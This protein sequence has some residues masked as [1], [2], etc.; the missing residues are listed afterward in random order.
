[1]LASYIEILRH[2]VPLV[3]NITNFV[4]MNL[5][6][7][8]QIAVGASPAMVHSMEE[9][10]EFIEIADA[11]TINIGTVDTDWGKSM[12]AAA[13]IASKINKPWVL[14]PVALGT[15]KFRHQLASRL[16]AIKPTVLRG[17]ASEIIA[18]NASWKRRGKGVDSIDTVTDAENAAK[19][20]AR[21]IA[22][23]VAV[24]GSVDFITNGEH[25]MRVF[26]GSEMMSKVTAIG[27]ALTG[28]IG[29]FIVD[30]Q[31]FGATIAAHA[32]FNYAGSIAAQYAAG[33]ATFNSAMIDALY[34]IKP[35]AINNEIKIE[36]A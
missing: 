26:G 15:T 36:E 28:V 32:C 5:V 8:T 21:C 13:S 31:P 7:N 18:L 25:S 9:V 1:M 17:N 23:V 29:A 10:T 22:G 14:D 2:K 20:L 16:L 12:L 33:P 35:S 19:Q 34:S 4:A 6:A 11:L 24:S 27:C 3:Q 30:Q